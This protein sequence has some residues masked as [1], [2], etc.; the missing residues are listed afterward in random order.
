MAELL[1]RARDNV[2]PDPDTDLR[3]SY[4]RGYVVVVKR[5]GW[6]WARAEALPNFVV[7]K[8]PGVPVD[9]VLKYVQPENIL[10]INPELGEIEVPFRRRRWQIRWADLPLSARTKLATTGQLI[11]KAVLA[12][13][14]AYDYTWLQVKQF[15]QDLKT[16]INETEDLA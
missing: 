13:D 7:I 4:K 15:F 16:S 11:I 2:H 6:P 5:D 10:E 14:G 1:I 8:I 9:K 12:Y 3:G